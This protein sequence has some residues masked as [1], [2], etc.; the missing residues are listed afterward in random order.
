MDFD[1]PITNQLISHVSILDFDWPITNDLISLVSI[2][3]FDWPI[4][5]DLISHVFILDFDWS[6]TND[7]I[8]HVSIIDFDWSITN[9]L[10]V[11][12]SSD[13]TTRIWDANTGQNIRILNDQFNCAVIACRF[14]P[15]NNNLIVV[16]F[17]CRSFNR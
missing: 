3:D 12:A 11:S 5:N 13:C 15:M 9:D 1:W 17:S 6:N 10:I 8:F 16:S 2:I 7:L 14:T 4:R